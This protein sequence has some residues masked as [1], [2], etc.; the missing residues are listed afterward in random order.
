[1]ILEVEG[2]AIPRLVASYVGGHVSLRPGEPYGEGHVICS[3]LVAPYVEGHKVPIPVV[4]Y[5][6]G[7]V[8]PR[9]VALYV[10]EHVVMR[11]GPHTSRDT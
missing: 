10:E 6:E 4:S 9:C 5:V 7:H 8:V 2:N 11:C 1:M 3:R